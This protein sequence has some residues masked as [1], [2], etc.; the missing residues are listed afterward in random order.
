MRGVRLID[1]ILSAA[2]M[3]NHSKMLNESK[4]I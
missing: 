2:A 3:T 1:S 4:V